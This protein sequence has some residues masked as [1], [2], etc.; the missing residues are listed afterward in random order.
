MSEDIEHQKIIE[1]KK[2]DE[3]D[4]PTGVAAVSSSEEHPQPVNRGK[5]IITT[6]NIT[7]DILSGIM[8]FLASIFFISAS[9][10]FH[11]DM[12]DKVNIQNTGNRQGGLFMTGF[13]LFG[14]ALALEF[15]K[16]YQTQG[17]SLTSA[18]VSMLSVLL[19][20]IASMLIV[21]PSVNDPDAFAGVFI[22]GSLML[23]ISQS[24]E[25]G[26]YLRREDGEGISN[27]RVT[28]MALSVL[29]SFFFFLAG[30]FFTEEVVTDAYYFYKA[31]ERHTA[32]F[33]V[34]SIAYLLHAICYLIGASK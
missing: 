23:G 19:L 31:I 15:P 12:W 11:Y 34:G 4:I 7:R 20:F 8:R 26:I 2:E 29:G 30:V 27:L 6:I 28:S 32:L 9:V 22:V 25:L 16:N 18:L 1:D 3:S 33:V 10:H 13:A 21:I 24:V 17:P 14:I 5:V